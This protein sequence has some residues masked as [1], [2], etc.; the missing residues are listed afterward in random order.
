M[1]TVAGPLAA[2]PIPLDAALELIRA[3][4]VNDVPV[5]VEVLR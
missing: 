5:D 1:H 4:L 3:S 2:D